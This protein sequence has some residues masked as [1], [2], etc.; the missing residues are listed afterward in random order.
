VGEVPENRREAT[1]GLGLR[2]AHAADMGEAAVLEHERREIER[3]HQD[4]ARMRDWFQE[5]GHEEAAGKL[6]KAM[7]PEAARAVIRVYTDLL[8][9]EIW[10]LAPD[11]Q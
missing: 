2:E 4:D 6:L 1:R 3:R 9:E 7:T 5:V 8:E 10:R 11:E